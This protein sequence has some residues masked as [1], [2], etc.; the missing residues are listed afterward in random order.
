MDLPS[1]S[2]NQSNKVSKL[3]I[4]S[5]IFAFLSLPSI[6]WMTKY[7]IGENESIKIHILAV[8][9]IG[10][11]ALIFGIITLMK[12]PNKKGSFMAIA[13]VLSGGI[14]VVPTLFL[15]LIGLVLAWAFR[16]G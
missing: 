6:F 12:H 7:F 9:P 16:A 15:L 5:L 8:F 11:V 1:N 13:G 2:P 3:A 14:I 4:V 10:A